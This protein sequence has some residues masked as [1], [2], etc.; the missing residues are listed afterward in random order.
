M[1][2]ISAGHHPFISH[3][4]MVALKGTHFPV[5]IPEPEKGNFLIILEKHY[6][7]IY[8]LHW[9]K[10]SNTLNWRRDKATDDLTI[11]SWLVEVLSAVSVLGTSILFLTLG[12]TQSQTAHTQQ[13]IKRALILLFILTTNQRTD[14][15]HR[16][17]HWYHPHS[18]GQATRK[19]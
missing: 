17:H 5:R 14:W 7:N 18:V 13:Q 9:C 6:F 10:N 8:C 1:V 3:I 4:L 15:N 2:S 11:T 16:E 19:V 12:N